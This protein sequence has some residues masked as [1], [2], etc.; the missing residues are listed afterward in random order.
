MR[1]GGGGALLNLY[2]GVV[3][4]V[5]MATIFSRNLSYD[6]L[7]YKGKYQMFLGGPQNGEG[8]AEKNKCMLFIGKFQHVDRFIIPNTSCYTD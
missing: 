7:L 1:G 2:K 4:V 8:G 3:V 6:K 5:G